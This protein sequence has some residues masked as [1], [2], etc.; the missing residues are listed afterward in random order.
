M[1]N[2]IKRLTEFSATLYTRI[3]LAYLG[4]ERKSNYKVISLGLGQQSTA[5]Y[6]MSSVGFI[7]RADFAVFADPGSESKATYKWW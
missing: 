3:L 5:M 2:L 6:L 7:E 4:V 1:K